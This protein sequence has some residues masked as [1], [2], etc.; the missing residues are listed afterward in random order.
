[1]D[2]LLTYA[3]ENGTESSFMSTAMWIVAAAGLWKMFEKAGEPGWIGLIP[4]YNQ[5]KLCEKVMGDPWYWLRYFVVLI[6][7]IGWFALF[8][9][10]YQVGKA[11]AKSYGQDEI[12]AWGY[13]FIDPICYCITGFGNYK[14]Y[15]VLGSGDHRTEDARRAKTVD[16]DVVKQNETDDRVV[17]N[18][19]RPEAPKEAEDVE[20]TLDRTSD[21]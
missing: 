12:W 3:Q 10:K 9:F 2:T 20:F 14:Y 21:D 7:V 11:T 13:T 19:V 1:M 18:D 4:G 15:G 16:F 6:P 17:I 8:Y 5:Y